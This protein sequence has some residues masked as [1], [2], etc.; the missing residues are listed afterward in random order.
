M[1]VVT[2]VGRFTKDPVEFGGDKKVVKWT[3]ACK[4]IAGKSDFIQCVAFDKKAELALRC[5]KGSLVSVYG[6]IS[7][8]V[9]TK[10]GEK[11]YTTNVL[12]STIEYCERKDAE[13]AE[14]LEIPDDDMPFK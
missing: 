8:S 1:N 9:Y 14:D 6:K 4:D 2:L 13:A 10:D 7:S 3:L 11:K 12:V 5:H